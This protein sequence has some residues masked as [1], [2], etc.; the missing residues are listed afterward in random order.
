MY[1]PHSRSHGGAS[2]RAGFALSHFGCLPAPPV[3][4]LATHVPRLAPRSLALCGNDQ[5]GAP[6]APTRSV[7]RRVGSASFPSST[8]KPFF[9]HTPI[10]TNPLTR[11]KLSQKLPNLSPAPQDSRS[12][13]DLFPAPPPVRF[14]ATCC[15][16]M[17][18]HFRSTLGLPELFTTQPVQPANKSTAHSCTRRNASAKTFSDTLW[19]PLHTASSIR[20]PQPHFL[21]G[22]CFKPPAQRR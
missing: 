7:G 21:D 16:P 17:R 8:C 19:F 6:R 3:R 22:S 10:A 11:N 12:G 18:C 2:S 14:V 5:L 9:R 20:W 1:N 15:R 4:G 13:G